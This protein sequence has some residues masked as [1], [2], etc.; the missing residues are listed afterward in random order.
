MTR[1]HLLQKSTNN[2]DLLKHFDKCFQ[3]YDRIRL[4]VF[5]FLCL[6]SIRQF[7]QFDNNELIRKLI[8]NFDSFTSK[9][10]KDTNK[11]NAQFYL[12]QKILFLV[13]MQSF[14]YE[15]SL[16]EDNSYTVNLLKYCLDTLHDLIKS[17][18]IVNNTVLSEYLFK[19][20]FKYSTILI[21]LNK[22]QTQID[23]TNLTQILIET[24]EM[25]YEESR[26]NVDDDSSKDKKFDSIKCHLLITR[27]KSKC[28]ELKLLNTNNSNDEKSYVNKYIHIITEQSTQTRNELIKSID[29]LFKYDYASNIYYIDKLFSKLMTVIDHYNKIH[30]NDS[31]KFH[32]TGN[33]NSNS[34]NDGPYE[35]IRKIYLNLRKKDDL[36][37]VKLNTLLCLRNLTFINE[38]YESRCIFVIL[39]F[40]KMYSNIF[41]LNHINY[42]IQQYA[43]HF[44]FKSI[45]AYIKT[46]LNFLITK[47]IDS[48]NDTKESPIESF[49]YKICFYKDRNEFIKDNFEIIY[50]N[51]FKNDARERV[52]ELC[53]RLNRD[54]NDYRLIIK[55]NFTSIIS[56]L[57]SSM[58]KKT[59]ETDIK[60][61]NSYFKK[62]LFEVQ[63]VK[64]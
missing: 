30:F 18:S 6:L 41:N 36:L 27:L 63:W 62:Q 8:D 64:K 3:L 16:N 39:R 40:N 54:S 59:I 60:R 56:F 17:N 49:P 45:E 29:S 7:N 15:R 34:V 21:S 25:A 42:I 44:Q 4:R 10:N 12:M 48:N 14:N 32:L 28:V 24:V 9:L 57:I 43:T 20:C 1:H 22:F 58:N 61:L 5:S 51:Y 11:S 23:L 2:F 46:H 31:S 13:N 52:E 35:S 50:N 19:I 26:L 37:N 53:K 33:E 47:W 38:N 55:D